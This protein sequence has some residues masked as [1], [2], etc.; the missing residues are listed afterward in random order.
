[1]FQTVFLSIIRSLILYIQHQVYAIQ[2]SWLLASENEMSFLLASGQQ[3]L[4]DIPDAVC[5]VLDSWWWTERPFETCRVLLRNKINKL[6]KLVH[7]VDFTIE[8]VRVVLVREVGLPWWCLPPLK[9]VG[10]YSNES[11]NQMQQFLRFIAC[12]LNIAEHVSS[13]LMPIIR[14]YNNCS[15][16]LW[17]TV[18]T[19][20]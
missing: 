5:T 13:I 11:T 10:M 7:L 2:V 15:S 17:F 14:S 3:N 12:L 8:T 19:W 6:E 20:W 9:H 1:M 4:N 16:S 18:G